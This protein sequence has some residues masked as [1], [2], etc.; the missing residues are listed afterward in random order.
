M[1]EIFSALSIC[2]PTN[3][4]KIMVSVNMGTGKKSQRVGKFTNMESVNNDDQPLSD[5]LCNPV[6]LILYVYKHN[7][8]KGAIALKR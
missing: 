2:M 5:F 3:N 1:S 4:H 7:F 6:P 8:V